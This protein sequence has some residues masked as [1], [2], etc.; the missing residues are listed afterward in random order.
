MLVD[1]VTPGLGLV[2]IEMLAVEDHAYMKLFKNAP[3]VPLFLDHVPFN[4]RD[5]GTTFAIFFPRSR[6]EPF[7][8]ESPY[9]TPRPFALR[10]TLRLRSCQA[11]SRPWTQVMQWP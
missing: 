4:F 8:A 6:T 2:K 11:S 10:E 3:L 5:F 9:W 7:Q 1:V